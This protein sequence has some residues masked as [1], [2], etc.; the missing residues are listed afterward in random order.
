[1]LQFNKLIFKKKIRVPASNP[2]FIMQ[3]PIFKTCSN[4]YKISTLIVWNWFKFYQYVHSIDKSFRLVLMIQRNFAFNPICSYWLYMNTSKV[5]FNSYTGIGCFINENIN[6]G[7][8]IQTV[9]NK[10]SDVYWYK[11]GWQRH[12]GH[13]GG[14]TGIN[15]HLD[16]AGQLCDLISSQDVSI[17]YFTLKIQ[18]HRDYY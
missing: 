2:S 15:I 14:L 16:L 1:M 13:V 9:K 7:K 4:N 12:R 3:A 5:L 11:Q 8:K 10:S 6:P 17:V 18:P